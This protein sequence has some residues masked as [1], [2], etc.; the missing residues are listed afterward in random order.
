MFMS[1]GFRSLAVPFACSLAPLAATEARGDLP[2]LALRSRAISAASAVYA[3]HAPGDTQ[4]LFC[5]IQS[6]TIRIL[7]LANFTFDET[8]FLTVPNVQS[9]GETGLLGL[10]F[11][12]NYAE[13]GYLYVYFNRRNGTTLTSPVVMRF[14]RDATNPDL[15]DPASAY[16]ILAVGGGN[17]LHNGGWISF[18]P[19]GYLYITNGDHG[20]SSSGQIISD[21][22]RG[23]VLRIDVDG[24]DFPDD[25]LRNYAVP[26]GNP[27][28]GIEG[29]DEIFAY[30]LRNPWRASIDAESNQMII[31]DVGA[32]REEINVL[33]LDVPG[34]NFGWPCSQGADID[35]GPGVT[36]VPSIAHYRTPAEPPLNLVGN[37]VIG[38]EIYRGCAIP[39]LRGRYVFGD[40]SG[41]KLSFVYD[42]TI[43]DVREHTV[44]LTG[45]TPYG[46]G[47]DA[48]GEIYI[49]GP[50]R[51]AKIIPASP[52]GRDCNANSVPD[53]CDVSSGN[54]ADANGD[55]V[56]DEC[57]PPGDVD[58]D[59]Q[60]GLTDIARL[61][62][63][64]GSCAGSASYDAAADFN[65][66]ACVELRDLA[67][68]LTNFVAE[69]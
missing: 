36:I 13:N 4:R 27:F 43:T 7:R 69:P 20:G 67:L 50:G 49:C 59:S 22:L 9:G 8:H 38:G 32:L 54:S 28:V 44:E 1:R 51:V 34:L 14:T 40:L 55:G 10:A 29:D 58:G 61:L 41:E 2:P 19:D 63:A 57:P 25:T 65:G 46:F 24:D 60:I 68:L 33:P 62:A 23:K 42:G 48:Y 15:A 16:E 5:V 56:P 17:G 30:G 47:H 66:D 21:N 11:H 53:A 6:G 12:P 26:P 45:I 37:S 64:F 31:G 18:G 52:I 39:P 3:T 35:C